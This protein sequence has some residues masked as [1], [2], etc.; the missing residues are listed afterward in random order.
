MNKKLPIVKD[1]ANFRGLITSSGIVRKDIK[2][3]AAAPPMQR[4]KAMKRS[5]RDNAKKASLLSG[6]V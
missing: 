3:Q 1:T 5:Q 4:R 6:T 2:K